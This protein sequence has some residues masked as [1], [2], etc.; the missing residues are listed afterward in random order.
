MTYRVPAIRK[1]T[2]IAAEGVGRVKLGN[3]RVTGKEQY[4][5]PPALAQEL[6]AHL[7]GLVNHT[8][9][10]F[11]ARTILEPAGG[12]GA[13]I[14]AAHAAGAERVLSFDIE[15]LHA[16]VVGGDFLEQ[17]L[18]P[19]LGAVTLGNPPFGRNNALSI[20]FFNHAAPH[21][22][23]IA[24]IVPRSWRKWTVINRLDR[25]FHLVSDEDL[26]IDYVDADGERLMV[27]RRLN[28]CFQ[29]WERRAELRPHYSVE[30][31]GLVSKVKPAEADVSLTVFGYNCGTV[32][33]SF[34]RKPNT[35]QMFLKLNH[36]DA[37]RA[38]QTVDFGRFFR[39]T[40]YTEALSL[41]EIN[42][43]LNEAITGNSHLV[44]EV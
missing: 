32:K 20:P 24:F 11:A 31:L 37:L 28:T 17:Q 7:V 15:P 23:F 8:D 19:V 2:T 1:R 21:S 14:D 4:Y 16:S 29:I 43:L 34:E 42:Y 30:D 22:D 36:P 27:K 40:A 38:L 33:T 9:A 35:T 13:F 10:T 18:G 39:Q 6:T 44:E 5:T 3:T 26:Q 41:S 25:N 12:T